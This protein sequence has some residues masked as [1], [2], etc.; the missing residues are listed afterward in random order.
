VNS[1]ACAAFL[2]DMS[3]RRRRRSRHDARLCHPPLVIGD[4]EHCARGSGCS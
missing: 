2:H 3:A 1:I 4:H